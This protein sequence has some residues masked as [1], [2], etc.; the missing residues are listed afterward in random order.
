MLCKTCDVWKWFVV[1]IFVSLLLFLFFL[2]NSNLYSK[3]WGS[4]VVRN[5]LNINWS[6]TYRK[7]HVFL[8][9]NKHKCTY[10]SAQLYLGVPRTHSLILGQYQGFKTR[11]QDDLSLYCWP[12]H[13]ASVADFSS[14]HIHTFVSYSSVVSAACWWEVVLLVFNSVL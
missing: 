4:Q 1:I 7:F 14:L 3:S 5:K 6:S 12:L 2:K 10:C 8:R 9:E 13:L 11:I